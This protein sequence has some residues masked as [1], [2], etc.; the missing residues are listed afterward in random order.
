MRLIQQ[1]RIDL[2]GGGGGAVSKRLSDI[3]HWDTKRISYGGEGVAQ[4]VEGD[5]WE[6]MISDK[7]GK[8][9]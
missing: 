8:Q 3:V 6:L 2:T 5:F 9:V 4:A 1:V 7:L